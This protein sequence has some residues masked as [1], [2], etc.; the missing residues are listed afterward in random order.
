MIINTI[1]II[2]IIISQQIV[3]KVSSDLMDQNE[4]VHNYRSPELHSTESMVSKDCT[5][6]L[7]SYFKSSKNVARLR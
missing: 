2:I 7:T 3:G 5:G 4:H 6:F 1:I